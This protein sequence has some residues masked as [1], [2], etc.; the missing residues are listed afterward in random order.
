MTLFPSF[1]TFVRILFDLFL[2]LRSSINL[3]EFSNFRLNLE[4]LFSRTVQATVASA[5]PFRHVGP[6]LFNLS[7][8]MTHVKNCF[9]PKIVILSTNR[10]SVI[11]EYN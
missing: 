2:N 3:P 9:V 4:T 8:G 10:P 6:G 7:P 11:L 5:H 1:D